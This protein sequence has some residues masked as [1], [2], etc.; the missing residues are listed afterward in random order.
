M[1][2]DEQVMTR[3]QVEFLR[4]LAI[5]VLGEERGRA[6]LDELRAEHPRPTQRQASEWISDLKDRQAR[7]PITAPPRS[8]GGLPSVAAGRYA[9][10]GDD[11][12][13]RLYKVDRPR[14]GHFSGWTFVT[15]M[16]PNGYESQLS[17]PQMEKVL[18]KIAANPMDALVAYGKHTGVCGKCGR[19]LTDPESIDAGIGPVCA[20]KVAM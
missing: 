6:Y 20:G 14:E 19:T 16:R 3:K 15:W 4:D 9:V 17:R 7:S 8:K 11:G 2:T 12:T 10:V 18:A 1:S 13:L 5:K